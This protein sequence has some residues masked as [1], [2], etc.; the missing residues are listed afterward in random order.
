VDGNGY[1]TT[2][3]WI[4]IAQYL[5]DHGSGP[6]PPDAPPGPPF[7]DAT[8]DGYVDESDFV[9]VKDAKCPMPVPPTSPW[10]NP[11]NPLDVSG[12]NSVERS[13]ISR[14]Q[15]HLW[16]YGP[17]PVPSDAIADRPFWDV[18]GDGFVTNLDQGLV[19]AFL[20]PTNTAPTVLD[21]RGFHVATMDAPYNVVRSIGLLDS[22]HDA[23]VDPLTPQLVSGPAHG[24]LALNE[25][26]S[27]I[28]TPST[29]YLGPDSFT[30]QVSDG[31]PEN[32]LS[33]VATVTLEVRVP[34][35]PP[36]A[37]NDHFVAQRDTTLTVNAAPSGI[38]AND[39]VMAAGKSQWYLLP[40]L[41]TPPAH[42]TVTLNSRIP[43]GMSQAE[44]GSFIY[45]PRAGFVGTDSFTYQVMDSWPQHSFSNVATVTIEVR[46]PTPSPP[47]RLDVNGD[48]EVSALDALLVFN[49]LSAAASRP[50]P[51]GE[52]FAARASDNC[53]VSGDGHVSAIDALL[54][55]NQLNARS[56]RAE[57]E[58]TSLTADRGQPPG[59]D[60]LLALLA[61][62]AA[63]ESR[64]RRAPL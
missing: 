51:E 3:D 64:R 17:H 31:R 34:P 10:Q 60:D 8:G 27:F 61:F 14:L 55:L 28:Y 62:D 57:A 7:Y 12:N 41:V 22:A 46:A 32:N 20:H 48:N 39:D 49:H 52:S 43:P 15:I 6:V 54:I 1:F 58:S 24:T 50:T 63:A 33:N 23:E 30:Y 9:L 47:N 4:L 44:R 53:D 13:D 37:G 36:V 40:I 21:N 25:D 35:E 26:G 45:V 18:N 19:A 11:C 5:G 56:T 29:G 2:L 16:H 42:G 59:S 38:L